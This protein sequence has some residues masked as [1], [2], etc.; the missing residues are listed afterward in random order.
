M[1]ELICPKH[2]CKAPLGKC[3]EWDINEITGKRVQC[4]ESPQMSTT[5]YWCS[6][7]NV[8]MYEEC[9]L[10][11][12]SKGKYITTDIRPVFPEEKVLLALLLGKENP[13]CF[14][15][16]S[17]WNN[18]NYYFIDGEK[19]QVSIKELQNKPLEEIKHIKEKYD[20]YVSKID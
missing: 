2:M 20:A 14:D 6:E 17:V 10:V 16:S 9:C 4:E 3:M 5:L 13:L 18:T 1:R 12:G 19:I 15:N 11:C 7:C 8:P